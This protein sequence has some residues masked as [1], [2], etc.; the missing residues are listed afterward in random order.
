MKI[1]KWS[2]LTLGFFL[3]FVAA[4]SKSDAESSGKKDKADS[5]GTNGV[6]KKENKTPELKAVPV[7]VTT[8]AAGEISSYV[9]TNASLETEETVDIFPQVTGIVVKLRAE[10]GQY[11]KKGDVLLDVD[12][13]EYKLREEAAR[14]NYDRQKNNYE[15]SKNMFDKKLLSDSEFEVANFSLEQARIEW[16]QAKLTLDYCNIKAPISGFISERT[17]KL[18]DRLLTSTKVYSIVNPDLLLAKIHLTEK[19]ALRTRAGQSAEILSEALPEHKFA[20]KVDRVSPVVDP[21]SGMVR[22]TIRVADRQ[23]LLKPGMFVNVHLITDTK[24]NAVLIPKKAVIYDDNQQFVYVVRQDTLAF[25]VQLKPGYTDRDRIEA[26][27]GL[28]IG[29]TIIVVGHSGMKDST[30][31]KIAE[32]KS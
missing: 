23:R 28:N 13:R 1:S 11:V 5:T 24:R 3:L 16:D 10:E 18:G 19:D 31:V 20:G 7:E 2:I 15:R 6:A 12:D 8:I 27:H 29:D 30:R 21:S 25:K 9:L 32:M 17:V 22:V 4:C 26:L 14:V